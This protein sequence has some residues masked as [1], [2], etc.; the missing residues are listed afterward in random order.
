MK[1]MMKVLALIMALIMVA[2]C[3]AACGDD[4][5]PTDPE[6]TT[7]PSETD[8]P[9][10]PEPTDPEPTDDGK[11][12]YKIIVK[13]SE[14]N[15]VSDLPVQICKE[16][17]TCFPLKTD[18]NGCATMRLNDALDYYGTVSKDQTIKEYFE[19]KFEVTLVYD[20]PE[21]PSTDPEETTGTDK[22][23]D[24]ADPASTD[25]GKKEYRIVVKDADGNP[26]SGVPVQVI[27]V[28]NEGGFCF[29]A[30]TNDNGCAVWSLD[31]ATDYYVTFISAEE[32]M[33]KEYFED[34]FEVTLV[35]NPPVEE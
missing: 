9:T 19:D 28:L 2:G 20:V 25:D 10:D 11:K 23:T 29:P 8:K 1:T 27:Q 30:I 4:A 7:A 14:G 32:G 34:K 18:E 3:L 24:P 16:G 22:S 17:S 13:D 5:K 31:E 12:E 6:G 26:V 35:Y 15:P 21:N 33:P